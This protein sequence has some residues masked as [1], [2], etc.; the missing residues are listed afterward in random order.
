MQEFRQ[1]RKKSN[2]SVQVSAFTAETV[3]KML[4]LKN[5]AILYAQALPHLHICSVALNRYEEE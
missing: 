2:D 4:I 3:E 1:R 5:E